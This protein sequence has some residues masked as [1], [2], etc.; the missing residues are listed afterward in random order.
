MDNAAAAG[1]R[2]AL[3]CICVYDKKKRPYLQCPVGEVD[4]DDALDEGITG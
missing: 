1:K 3:V 4:A 2:E